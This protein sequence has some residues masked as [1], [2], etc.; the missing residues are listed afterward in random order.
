MSMGWQSESALLPSK[1]TPIN[2]DTKSMMS[3]KALVYNIEQKLSSKVNNQE[4]GG[5]RR[6]ISKNHMEK[7]DSKAYSKP[8]TIK[9][10]SSLQFDEREE[11]VTASLK[12]KAAVYDQMIG[13]KGSESALQNSSATSG[14][15]PFLINFDDKRKSRNDNDD[16]D[17]D[18][19]NTYNSK[20]ARHSD[21]SDKNKRNE[22]HSSSSSN[23]SNN[24]KNFNTIQ[25][26]EEGEI[27]MNIFDQYGRSKQV[28]KNSLE[29]N[30]YI[31]MEI[32][33][34]KDKAFTH[35]SSKNQTPANQ[36]NHYLFL[37]N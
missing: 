31:D 35:S 27:L 19:N 9:E 24:E 12:A 21:D 22:N 29:Y 7:T 10:K 4:E 36:G 30:Q 18:D 5:Y 25:G 13:N 20:S 15:G 17:D 28:K 37:S 34:V 2:V 32:Q 26:E 3:M 11:K 14:T 1:A 8:E 23:D 16:D 6:K 33:K